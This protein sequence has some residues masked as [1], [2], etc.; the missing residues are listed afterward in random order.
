MN[1]CC[2]CKDTRI[3]VKCSSIKDIFRYVGTSRNFDSH[4]SSA[5]KIQLL[6]KTTSILFLNFIKKENQYW[7]RGEVYL[8]KGGELKKYQNDVFGH[9]WNCFEFSFWNEVFVSIFNF[10]NIE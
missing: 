5:I 2:E 3:E 8:W 6:C 7:G 4:I 1:R 10:E 9:H